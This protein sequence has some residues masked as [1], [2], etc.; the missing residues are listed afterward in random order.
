MGALERV[1]Q[2]ALALHAWLFAIILVPAPHL[3]LLMGMEYGIVRT[4]QRHVA[5]ARCVP[6]PLPLHTLAYTSTRARAR[7]RTHASHTH[8]RTRTQ[9]SQASQAEPPLSL[10]VLLLARFRHGHVEC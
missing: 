8:A 4:W 3:L 5:S 9:A 7:T 6:L 1:C 10:T 2:R